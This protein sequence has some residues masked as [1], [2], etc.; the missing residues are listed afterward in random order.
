[1]L[2]MR[3]III[4]GNK[5]SINFTRISSTAVILRYSSY[6]EISLWNA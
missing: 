6:S 3:K 5:Y 2:N 1:M 4:N